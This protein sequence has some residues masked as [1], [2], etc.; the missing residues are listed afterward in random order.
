M[1][2]LLYCGNNKIFKGLLISVVSIAKNTKEPL[3][4]HIMTM[5]LQNKNP[6]FI[7]LSKDSVEYIETVIKR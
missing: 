7:P 2:S 1:I 3:D 4:V 5:D 6:S